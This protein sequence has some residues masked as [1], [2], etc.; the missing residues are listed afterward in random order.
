MKR[1]WVGI[2]VTVAGIAVA[3]AIV[4]AVPD[5][6]DAAGAAIR[7]DTEE[8]RAEID[9]LGATG[10][11]IVFA[12]GL[13]HTVVFYPAE[14]LDTA[15]GFAYG[16][17]GGVALVHMAWMVSAM[18]AYWIGSHAGRPFLYKLAGR[19]RFRRGEKLVDRGGITFLLGVRLIPIL[20]F[21][22]V[23]FVCGA[24]QVPFGRY[25]WTTAIGY[26]P[27]T[28]A[29]VYFGS[30]LEDLS[31][32]DPILLGSAAVVAILVASTLWLGPKLMRTDTETP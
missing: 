16:F 6:R 20:P 8:L 17:W 29:F 32:T 9:S 11:L 5:L 7:G 27:I 31:P 25:M 14:I 19:E 24:A 18:L 12:L 13:M 4:L 26:L 21:S 10:V 30:R 1:G 23:C 15:A 3:A 2:G 22:V 28:A